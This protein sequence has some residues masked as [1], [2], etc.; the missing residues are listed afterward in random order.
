[1]YFQQPKWKTREVRIGSVIIGGN[2]PIRIQSMTTSHTQNIEATYEQI[3]KLQDVGCEL[4]RITVQ[5]MKEAA[6]CYEIKNLMMQRGLMVPLIADIHFFPPAA[7]EVISAVDKIRINPGNFAD[8]R[9]SL[10][11][12]E[13]SEAQYQAGIHRIEEVFIPLIS[14]CK[15][16]GKALRIGVN[17][18]SLSDRILHRYGDTP[19]GMVESAFEYGRICR[20]LDYHDLV[21]SMKS[22]HTQVMIRAYRHLVDRM[23][24][25]GWDYPLHLG[26]TEAGEGQ[27]GRIKSAIG[28]GTLLLDGIGDTIRFSLTEDP[29]YEI[30]PCQRLRDW[31]VDQSKS[32][33]NVESPVKVRVPWPL[34]RDGSVILS[35]SKEELEYPDLL[36]QLGLEWKQGRWIKTV[37]CVDAVLIQEIHPTIEHLQ[38]VGV[39]VILAAESLSGVF[40]FRRD[41]HR[42]AHGKE[43]LPSIHDAVILHFRYDQLD[44]ED[45]IL[46]SAAE[47]GALL[48]EG[49]A[50]GIC[51]DAPCSP[52]RRRMIS[53]SILQGCRLRAV[54]TEYISCPSCG[55]T[56]FDLQEVSKQVREK[57]SHLP[58]VKIAIMGCIVNGPGEMADADFGYVGSQ[59][60]KI[61]LYVNK[62]RR[63]RNIPMTEAVDRLIMCIQQE[64]RWVPPD[65]DI[66]K[67]NNTCPV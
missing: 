63:E 56:L 13:Y 5:G 7:L 42:V 29:W 17:H 59:P 28:I 38:A 21:F 12:K 58:G 54:K 33:R 3:T 2:H 47:M 67:K 10:Q 25:E 45:L 11:S 60:G 62:E 39:P 40:W 36:E 32:I 24:V 22:S 19:E 50:Q 15:K 44:E 52:Q 35:L 51:L 16:E 18:G 65:D 23:L 20:S 46:R 34:H 14:R 9:A 48:S 66:S 64:G 43:I 53:F 6:A 30:A 37:A 55:R 61:D 1:M 8:P 49:L 41:N 31:I 26:V 27:E 4:V 57:T